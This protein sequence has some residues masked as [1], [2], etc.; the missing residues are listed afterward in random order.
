MRMQ[1]LR[2]LSLTIIGMGFH[3]AVWATE[4]QIIPFD[5]AHWNFIGSAHVESYLGEKALFLGTIPPENPV[6][7][8]LASLK[9]MSFKTGIIEYQIAF[10]EHRAFTGLNFRMQS[11]GNQENF[12]LRTHHSGEPD[13]TQYM[14]V[15]NDVPSWQLHHGAQYSVDKTFK[16]NEWMPVKM[17]VAETV[18]DIY[19]QDLEKPALTI[20]LERDPMT[21]GLAFW[22]LGL[23]GS[24]NVKIATVKVTPMT[25]PEIKGV[26]APM[27]DAMS[28]T[29]TA[30]S[31]SSA[32]DAKRLA[33][34]TQLTAEDTQDLTYTALKSD[35]TGMTNLAKVQGLAEAKDTVLAKVMIES[36]Q[37]QVKALD[38]GFS[39]QV[40]VYLN[41]QLLFHGNDLMNSRDYRFLGT[42]GYYDTVY[43]PLKAGSN[44]LSFAVSELVEDPTGWGLTAR[45]SA[46]EGVSVKLAE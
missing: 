41:G 5:E 35:A 28:G 29:I 30:W 16:F 9:D 34:K 37:D 3:S 38:F 21:G 8:G 39:D 17:V 24:G 46:P 45:F 25:D 18:A 6:G 7:F 27:E 31:V 12:Y 1:N 2:S 13:A 15:Y 22:C 36:A 42:V 20:P 23:S 26:V 44:E 11:G 10:D 4:S 40:W 14:P 32:F 43:L 19:I 33:D